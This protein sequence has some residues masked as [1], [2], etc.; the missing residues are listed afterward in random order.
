M[1]LFRKWL[2]TLI[3]MAI[4]FISSSIPGGAIES[5]GLGKE[6]YHINGHFLFF[7]ILGLCL[8]KST[9]N[10]F[11]SILLTSL[12]GIFDEFHQLYTPLRSASLFDVF[13]DT[14]GGIISGIIIWKSNLILPKKLQIWL[15]N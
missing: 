6:A 8:Y 13:V 14:I 5:V 4:I 10:I 1:T 2:P 9:K 11:L 15:K 12:Y 3:V 7:L